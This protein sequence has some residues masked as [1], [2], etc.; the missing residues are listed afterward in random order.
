MYNTNDK[1]N[2]IQH[3]L[4]D[5]LC[6]VDDFCKEHCITYFLGGGT[7]LGAVREHGFITWDTDVD[8]MLPRPDYDKLISLYSQI[9]KSMYGL[10]N[11][12]TDDNCYFCYSKLYDKNTIISD[13]HFTNKDVGIGIDIFPID[14]ISNNIIFNKL[15]FRYF[16]ISQLIILC[17]CRKEFYPNERFKLLKSIVKLIFKRFN[18]SR[19]IKFI[20]KIAK[21]FDYRNSKYAG[22]YLSLIKRYFGEKEI[23]ERKIWDETVYFEFEGRKFPVFSGYHEYLTKHYGDYMVPRDDGTQHSI[24]EF[25]I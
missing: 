10:H 3:R 25:N 6:Y 16:R 11:A 23:H 1:I 15:L 20:E 7:C 24:E 8:I 22:A 18:S 14:G 4:F 13:H 9:D 5:M 12:Y 21:S 19:Y 2:K 17:I